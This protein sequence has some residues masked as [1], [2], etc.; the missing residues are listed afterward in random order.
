MCRFSL[1]AVSRGFVLVH[2]LLTAVASLTVEHGLQGAQAS[3][4]VVQGLTCLVA[5]ANPYPLHC[6]VDSQP[7][8][9][10]ASPE[11]LS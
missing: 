5:R 1:V 9:G 7:P 10:Q 3:A 8:D 6:Q 11:L 2:G 4:V